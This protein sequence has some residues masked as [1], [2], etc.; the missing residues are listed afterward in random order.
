MT[1]GDCRIHA[2]HWLSW[3]I[4]QN[5]KACYRSMSGHY[6]LRINGT[7]VATTVFFLLLGTMCFSS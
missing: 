6:R 7:E 2:S 5:K 1:D 4:G 3:Q